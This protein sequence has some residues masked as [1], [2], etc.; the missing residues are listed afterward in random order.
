MGVDETNCI[1][2][3]LSPKTVKINRYKLLNIINLKPSLVC[4]VN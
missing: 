1:W 4:V 2:K 3:M